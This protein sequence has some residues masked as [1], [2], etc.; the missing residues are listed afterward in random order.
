MVPRR[1][2]R[3]RVYGQRKAA[4][5]IDL[6]IPVGVKQ[7]PLLECCADILPTVPAADSLVENEGREA[8]LGDATAADQVAIFVRERLPR[9]EALK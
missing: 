8:G 2:A 1:V 3:K 7:G 9:R 5:V 4:G 6:V